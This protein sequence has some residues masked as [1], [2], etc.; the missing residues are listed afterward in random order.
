MEKLIVLTKESEFFPQDEHEGPILGG[1]QDGEVVAQCLSCGKCWTQ[2]GRILQEGDPEDSGCK[3][4]EG[5]HDTAN[6]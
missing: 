6:R 5:K 1:R 2:S 4:M 3:I